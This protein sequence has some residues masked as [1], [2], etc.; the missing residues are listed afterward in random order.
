MP[1]SLLLPARWN[2]DGVA[3]V[4]AAVLSHEVVT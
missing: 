3:Q 1:S 4:E 2:E